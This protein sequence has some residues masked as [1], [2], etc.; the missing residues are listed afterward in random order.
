MNTATSNEFEFSFLEEG[1]CARDIVEQ[2]INESSMTVSV[3]IK[4]PVYSV[5]FFFFLQDIF[6]KH[7]SLSSSAPF[8]QDDRDAFYV[9]D[10][11]DVLK[12]HLRWARALPRVTPFYAVKCN[13]SRAVVMTL[14]SLGAGFDCASKV[15][16]KVSTAPELF[17]ISCNSIGSTCV[18][19]LFF[20]KPFSTDCWH[21][22]L[23]DGNSPGSV[24]GSRSK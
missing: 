11:G 19:L 22:F 12:K 1:F 14:A 16:W 2:K 10:L 21:C 4:Y 20:F 8:L 17:M 6:I 15:C 9:C 13:D 23:L 24:S 7:M 18:F 3:C 5:F